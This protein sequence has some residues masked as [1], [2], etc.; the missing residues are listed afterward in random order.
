MLSSRRLLL[1]GAIFGVALIV[2]LVVL[3]A[4]PPERI[5]P[6]LEEYRYLAHNFSETW[7]YGFQKDWHDNP[8]LKQS[9]WSFYYDASGMIRSPGYPAFIAGI[10]AVFGSSDRVLQFSLATLD[11]I[12]AVVIGRI[13]CLLFVNGVGVTAALLYAFNPNAIQCINLCAREPVQVFLLSVAVWALLRS[14]QER[15]MMLAAAAGLFFGLATIVKETAAVIALVGTGWVAWR[16]LC[17]GAGSRRVFV[18]LILLVLLVAPWIIRN[19][20]LVGYPTGMST[21]A[22]IAMWAGLVNEDVLLGSNFDWT[23]HIPPMD[24]VRLDPY[25]A[26]SAAEADRRINELVRRY[27]VAHPL[28]VSKQLLWNMILFWSPVSRTVVKEG[29][30]ARPAELLSLLYFC[31]IL[32]LAAAGIFL[33][34][35][36]PEARLALAVVLAMTVAH[37]PFYAT[38]RY[39]IQI[40]MFLT[41]YAAAALCSLASH[42][43]KRH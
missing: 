20:L 38:L 26:T 41:P 7:R 23:A 17:K 21:A 8:V 37:A 1:D 39:R 15:T 40:E 43:V 28:A 10:E 5:A 31:A 19:S 24:R 14:A 9:P 36:P 29:F 13:A 16:D 6:D 3:T 32:T 25:G 12:S 30:D 11:A 27:A 4:L 42:L 33:N 18:L 35:R 2:R 22:A 34:R